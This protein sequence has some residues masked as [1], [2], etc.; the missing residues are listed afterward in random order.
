MPENFNVCLFCWVFSW[1]G[2]LQGMNSTERAPKMILY[3]SNTEKER[4][5]EKEKYDSEDPCLTVIRVIN[6][7]ARTYRMGLCLYR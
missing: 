2:Y 1:H 5:V 3:T 4:A 6:D 7:V